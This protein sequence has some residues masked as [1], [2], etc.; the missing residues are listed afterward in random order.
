MFHSVFSSFFLPSVS[1]YY[2]MVTVVAK[3]YIYDRL[4]NQKVKNTL[5]GFA[6][7]AGAIMHLIGTLL[8]AAVNG[9]QRLLYCSAEITANMCNGSCWR[10]LMDL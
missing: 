10:C 8:T 6:S 1:L 9:V 5:I 4:L 2:Y 7:D 3:C